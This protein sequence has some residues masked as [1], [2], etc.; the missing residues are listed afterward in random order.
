MKVIVTALKAPWPKGT[1][2]DDMVSIDGESVPAWALGKCRVVGGD[3]PQKEAK[4]EA[5]AK[6]GKQ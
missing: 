5:K 3:E 1:K 4:A 6:G 2:V